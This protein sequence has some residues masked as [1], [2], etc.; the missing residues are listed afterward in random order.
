[1]LDIHDVITYPYFDGDQLRSFGM[2]KGQILHFSIDLQRCLNKLQEWADTN[3]FKF[4]TSKT[5]CVHFCHLRKF[6]SDPQLLLNGSPIPVV[7]E[8]KFFG[9]IVDKK[10]LISSSLALLEK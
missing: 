4:S 1:M 8:V 3:G 7:E 5:V 2:V 9:I 6:H 10:T